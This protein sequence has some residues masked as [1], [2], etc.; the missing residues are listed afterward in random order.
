MRPSLLLA[1]AS[2]L[3]FCAS[4]QTPDDTEKGIA[5]PGFRGPDRNG[6]APAANPPLEWGDAENLTW[7]LRLPGA[8]SSSPIVLGDRVYVACYSGYGGYLDDGGDPEELAHHLVCVDRATGAILWDSDLPG[9]VDFPPPQVQLTEHGFASPTPVTDGV[10]IFTYFGRAGVVAFDLD[11]D[12]LWQTDLGKPDPN[13]EPPTNSVTQGGRTIPLRWGTAASP[14]L[15]DGLVIVN[16]SEQ[17]NSI[18]A[19]D[20]KTGELVWKRESSNLE[21]SAISPVI[22]GSAGEQVL[23]V[24]L[25]G[26]VWGMTPG[27]GE[28]LWT[29]E[30]GSRGGMSATPV[31]DSEHVFTFG[32]KGHA[33]RLGKNAAQTEGPDQSRITWTGAN[34]SIPSPV[35]YDGRLFLVQMSGIATCIQASDGKIL[36]EGRLEGRTS[37]VYASPVL[38][39]GRLY[40]VSRNRGTFVYSTDGEFKLLAHNEL[41]DDSQFNASP[42][43]VGTQLYM[44]SD[45]FLYRL[46]RS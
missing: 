11:G 29:V 24:V 4:G 44:R 2:F 39:G 28:T 26:E 25:G 31:F 21:G 14:L 22:V 45:K 32:G 35:L 5:W 8:G 18:R 43:V 6:V 37:G 13:A 20:K 3:A 16:A 23:I 19:L 12:I 10:A 40:V 41:E 30:T 42:A 9:P 34:L 7:K 46:D 38:A 1:A 36:H 27:T 33:L 17:S 15:H